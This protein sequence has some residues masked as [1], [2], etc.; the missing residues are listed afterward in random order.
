MQR[1]AAKSLR[2][3]WFT[4]V[5]LFSQ[6]AGKE[7]VIIV[8]HDGSGMFKTIQEALNSVPKNNSRNRV[9]LIKRGTYHEKL[10]IEKSF[11]TLV[12]E[13]QDSTLIVYAELRE[14]WNKS[15]NGSDWGAA[16]VNIDSLATD[17]TLANLTVHNNYGSLYH[18]SRHQFAIR[19]AAHESS[20]SIVTLSL[21]EMTR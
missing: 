17:I 14:N 8:A 4:L 6:A 7:P 12:G 13:D 5:C 20:F 9:I 16:V 2:L 3:L 11:V 15:R 21:T 10:F 18:T 1:I 19:G